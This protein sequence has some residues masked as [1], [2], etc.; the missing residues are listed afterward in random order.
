M[1]NGQKLIRN[2]ATG[3]A[4]ALSIMIVVGIGKAILGFAGYSK[5]KETRIVR[6]NDSKVL[7]DDELNKTS[8]NALQNSYNNV[9]SIYIV[10][11]TGTLDVIPTDSDEVTVEAKNVSDD[12]Y[13]KEYDNGSIEII[14]N[15]KGRKI[16]FGFSFNSTRNKRIKVYVPKN[17]LLE[18]FELEAGAGNIN[19]RDLQVSNLDITAGV[20]NIDGDSIKASKVEIESGVGN[21]T[22]RDVEFGVTDISGGV[23]E[24]EVRGK[25]D[26]NITLS[27]GVGNLRLDL[28]GDINDYNID[29]EKGL[30]SIRIN[31]DS[32][33]RFYNK[34]SKYDI[35]Y[36]GGVGN[37]TINI[38]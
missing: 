11:S 28:E 12:F 3:F 20:G 15:E 17:L 13:V 18:E 1:S 8:N 16:F 32:T 4:L 9:K 31:G 2:I 36:E 14:D 25:I 24:I 30:G 34:E 5:F 37:I 29:G 19:I 6:V 26:G 27:A 22:L 7:D 38:K 23:G 10:H 21:T 35:D 33:S